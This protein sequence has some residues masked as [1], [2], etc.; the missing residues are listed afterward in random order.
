MT[1]Q[2]IK[3]AIAFKG[4]LKITFERLV[5]CWYQLALK[6]GKSEEEA[7]DIAFENLAEE[8]MGMSKDIN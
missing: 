8:I 3:D 5:D 6:E 2:D 1:L 4:D 7:I